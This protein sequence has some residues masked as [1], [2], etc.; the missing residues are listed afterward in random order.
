MKKL[1]MIGICLVALILVVSCATGFDNSPIEDVVS[2]VEVSGVSSADLFVKSNSW[3]VDAFKNSESVIQFS[4]KEAGV[5]KGKFILNN[6]P[7]GAMG[8]KGTIESTITIETKEGKARISLSYN[9]A[10]TDMV[11]YGKYYKKDMG[12]AINPDGRKQYFA[13]CDGMIASFTAAIKS[14]NASW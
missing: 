7:I 9:N 10:Y 12:T 2:V 4:D 6:M 8:V 5:I 13:A 14:E 11:M 3:M 1:L